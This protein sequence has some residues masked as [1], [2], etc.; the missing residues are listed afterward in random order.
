M[1]SIV[2]PLFNEEENIPKLYERIV[3]A[4][5]TWNSP[6]EAILVDD[7]STDKTLSL[8]RKLYQNDSR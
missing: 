6:F 5:H 3:S 1:L 4:S 2:I 7:G 8:L